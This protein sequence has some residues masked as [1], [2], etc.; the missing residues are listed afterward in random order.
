[1]CMT[2]V[3]A[4][5]SQP[6]RPY[7]GLTPQLEAV[8]IEVSTVQVLRSGANL[9]YMHRVKHLPSMIWTYG[10]TGFYSAQT[11]YFNLKVL[12]F[13]KDENVQFIKPLL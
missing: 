7:L 9:R 1:M 4:L 11:C 10:D 12:T 8:I 3:V 6:E 13:A 5:V 2:N